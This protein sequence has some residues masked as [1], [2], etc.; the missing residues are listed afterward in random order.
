MLLLFSA[1]DGGDRTI[2]LKGGE[3]MARQRTGAG[4]AQATSPEAFARMVME[5]LTVQS[6]LALLDSALPIRVW[7][8]DKP[9]KIIS[10]RP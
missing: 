4:V 2:A 10:L 1:F 9:A 5:R 7:A 3:L 6:A 8:K